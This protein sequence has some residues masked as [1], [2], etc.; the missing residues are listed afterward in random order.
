MD[1]PVGCAVD[2]AGDGAAGDAEFAAEVGHADGFFAVSSADGADGVGAELGWPVA[3]VDFGTD[4]PEV[5]EA[6]VGFVV[7]DVVYFEG[8]V[9]GEGEDT[10]GGDPDG[11]VFADMDADAFDDDA[12][13]EVAVGG[14]AEG[15]EASGSAVGDLAA[16]E[17][18]DP[19]AGGVFVP[20]G[21][22]ACVEEGRRAGD[23]RRFGRGER[24]GEGHSFSSR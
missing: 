24:G 18:V 15:D 14:Y 11:T 5:F 13:F 16:G 6:A 3:A 20:C 12:C 4:E 7:V 17:V 22:V 21:V 8:V 23:C 9:D 2:D 19:V 1:A 10:V